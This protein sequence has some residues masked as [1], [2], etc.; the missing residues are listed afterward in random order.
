MSVALQSKKIPRG[1]KRRNEIAGV[2]ERIFLERGYADTAM[3]TIAA[4]A[5]ASKETLYRHFGC[6]EA[7]FSEV[8]RRRSLRITGGEEGELSGPPQAVLFD[9]ARNL[10]RFLSGPDSLRLYRVVVAE[11]PRAP[12]LGRIFYRQGPGRL[13]NQLAGYLHQAALRGELNC[14][15]CDRAAKLFLGAVVSY[16]QMASLV[17]GASYP[18]EELLAYAQEAV[19]LFLARYGA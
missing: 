9:V 19:G 5:G 1:E 13:L 18:D 4:E 7:L 11:T 12:E 8:V 17:L 3:H 10:L 14:P 16:H 6:K 15:D 2:A